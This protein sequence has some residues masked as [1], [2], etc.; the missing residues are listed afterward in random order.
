MSHLFLSKKRVGRRLSVA[1]F[2]GETRVIRVTQ[3]FMKAIKK[4]NFIV[5]VHLE[6]EEEVDEMATSSKHVH[7]DYWRS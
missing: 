5:D 4:Q 7:S 1:V 2:E 3:F 6:E